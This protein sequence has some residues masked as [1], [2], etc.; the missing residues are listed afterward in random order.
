MLRNHSFRKA[1]IS[2][3][4]AFVAMVIGVMVVGRGATETEAQVLGASIF[5]TAFIALFVQYELEYRR[6]RRSGGD[7]S[8]SD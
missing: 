7:A 5:V 8:E 4:F 6:E 2:I 3:G 1:N